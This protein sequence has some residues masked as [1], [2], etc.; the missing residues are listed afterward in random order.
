M[1]IITDI[2]ARL[3]SVVWKCT[4]R[5]LLQTW[6][7]VLRKPGDDKGAG[8]GSTCARNA[9]LDDAFCQ[10]KPWLQVGAT[11]EE[12]AKSLWVGS[13]PITEVLCQ[14]AFNLDP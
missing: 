14:S 2:G 13:L 10:T 1:V 7:T 5:C 12:G 8:N 11:L 9:V 4:S 6:T 3:G